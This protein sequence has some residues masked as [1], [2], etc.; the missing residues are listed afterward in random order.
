MIQIFIN[1][2]ILFFGPTGGTGNYF[3]SSV[4]VNS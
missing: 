2:I 1:L 4:M 3:D